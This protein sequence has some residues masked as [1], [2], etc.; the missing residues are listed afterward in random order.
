[1]EFGALRVFLCVLYIIS[2]S[3]QAQDTVLDRA[4]PDR[5][6]YDFDLHP[7]SLYVDNVATVAS[8]PDC[9][10]ASGIIPAGQFCGA[11]G[12]FDGKYSVSVCTE[13][14]IDLGNIRQNFEAAAAYWTFDTCLDMLLSSSLYREC[15][16]INGKYI[17]FENL[18][19]RRSILPD[20]CIAVITVRTLHLSSRNQIHTMT[21]CSQYS[22]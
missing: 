9:R 13:N 22:L 15:I 20:C 14:E 12:A 17:V 18:K 3:A 5:S 1:M 4:L 16:Q 21:I 7:N 2:Q 10:V 6:T 11:Q 8:N 19:A